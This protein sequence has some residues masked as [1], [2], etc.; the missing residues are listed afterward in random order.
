MLFD[1]Q[2]TIYINNINWQP[3]FDMTIEI[4]V[5]IKI[6]I[7]A[8]DTLNAGSSVDSDVSPLAILIV[9]AN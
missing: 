6:S 1:N 4:N 8:V 3:Y 2:Q 7:D 5:N 9:P